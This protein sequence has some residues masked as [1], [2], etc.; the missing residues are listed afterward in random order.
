MND[1]AQAWPGLEGAVAVVTGAASGQGRLTARALAGQGAR[2]VLVDRDEHVY[3]AAELCDGTAIVGDVSDPRMWDR[4]VQ[5]TTR[6]LGEITALVNN[7]GVFR[8]GDI[9]TTDPR[10]LDLLYRVNQ[11]APM[12]AARAVVP[13]MRRAR[14]G[15]IVNISSTAGLCGRAGAVA[16][17]A[18][19]WA[20][21]GLSRALAA[22]LAPDI[23]VNTVLPGLIDTPMAAAN[24]IEVNT[25]IVANT[26]L[27]RIGAPAEV[28]P[29]TLFLLSDHASFLTGT[30]IVVDG[31]LSA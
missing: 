18:T 3:E 15:S 20:V 10:E 22:E 29:A 1:N 14:R 23:R 16:Y 21:R 30:E 8:V 17:T 24:G 5:D 27:G 19:K 25:G 28:V 9:A 2:V 12:L 7:A 4:F 26:P 13:S 6:N 11:L 31:G